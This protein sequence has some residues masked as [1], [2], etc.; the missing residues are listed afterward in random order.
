MVSLGD[1]F[2]SHLGCHLNSR[3]E[4][5]FFRRAWPRTPSMIKLLPGAYSPKASDNEHMWGV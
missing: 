5:I 3:G 2:I 4:E 1:T